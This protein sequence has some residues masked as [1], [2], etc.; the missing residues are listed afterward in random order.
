MTV[1][2]IPGAGEVWTVYDTYDRPVMTQ[3][4]LLRHD[5]YWI[6]TKYDNLNRPDSIGRLA[7]GNNRAYH[8]NLAGTSSNYPVISGTGY[9]SYIRTFYD[10]Y[11]WLPDGSPGLNANFSTKYVNNSN[12]FITTPNVGPV[13]AQP[14]IQTPLT[15]GMVTGEATNIV[16][17]TYNLY[18]V[19]FYDDRT[20][21]IQTISSNYQSGIDTST[22]QFD[23]SGKPLRKLITQSDQN[24][25]VKL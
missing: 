13:Y 3:D 16:G 19:N 6:I 24:S 25:Q 4:S 15:R 23:F 14:I 7:D 1:K 12:Y 17:S 5:G 20:R 18:K 8:Q 2:K 9:N 10:N 21:L 11:N 22:Y